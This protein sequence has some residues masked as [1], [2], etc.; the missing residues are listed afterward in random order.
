MLS[1]L[2][3]TLLKP[4]CSQTLH[5]KSDYVISMEKFQMHGFV[6]VNL[7]CPISDLCRNTTYKKYHKR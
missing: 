2:V 1:K 4:L 5:V 7:Q 3:H 6:N